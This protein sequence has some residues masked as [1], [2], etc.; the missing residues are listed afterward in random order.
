L[1]IKKRT[2]TITGFRHAQK[3]RCGGVSRRISVAAGALFAHTG[4]RARPHRAD[5]AD[6]QTW[7][8]RDLSFYILLLGLAVGLAVGLMGVGGGIILVP[9][10]VYLLHFKQ[11]LAQGTSLFLQLAPIGLGALQSYWKKGHVD[12]RAGLVCAGGFFVGGYFGSFAALKIP[13]RE[14]EL[15]F[16]VFL[17]G[18]ALLLL[19]QILDTPAGP[20]ALGRR[21]EQVPQADSAPRQFPEKQS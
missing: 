15:I 4:A 13:A 6:K 12:V 18:S 11:H 17:M 21:A 3:P 1:A 2:A 8:A 16:G 7:S 10:L 19:R 9:A 20:R 5:Q 14:L